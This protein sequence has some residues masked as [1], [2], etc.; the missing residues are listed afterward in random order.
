MPI[1]PV[2]ASSGLQENQSTCSSLR[3]Q[4]TVSHFY[5]FTGVTQSI[6]SFPPCSLLF[7][8]K[9]SFQ[10][11]QIMSLSTERWAGAEALKKCVTFARFVKVSW[12]VVGIEWGFRSPVL[13][14]G[15]NFR[16]HQRKDRPLSQ[17]PGHK[18]PLSAWPGLLCCME[19]EGS[20]SALTLGHF[21][22]FYAP[23]PQANQSLGLQ[24]GLKE[25]YK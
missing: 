17:S 22:W 11:G 25:T 16:H 1:C 15:V 10:I 19:G 20:M 8:L 12:L 4:R 13:L 5:V 18:N 6:L 2:P 7:I 21:Y 23:G 24:T 14:F 3:P 9:N